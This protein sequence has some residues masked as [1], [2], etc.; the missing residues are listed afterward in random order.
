MLRRIATWNPARG[1]WET[2]AAALCGHWEPYSVTWPGSGMTRSGSAFEPPTSGL[3]TAA[4]ASS[5][6]PHLPTPAARD[7]KGRDL[8]RQGGPSLPQA[9]HDLAE[10]EPETLLPTP[11]AAVFNDGQSPEVYRA[12]KARELAK[13]YN[14]NGGGT[15]LAMAVR[16]LPTILA[17]SGDAGP[18][19]SRTDRPEA[20]GDDLLTTMVKLLPTTTA[21]DAKGSRRAT[22]RRPGQKAHTGTTLTDAAWRLSGVSTAPPSDD[23]SASS[24]EPPPPRPAPDRGEGNGSIPSSRSG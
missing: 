12:R 9:I 11:D 15:P 23:G 4:A 21:T 7:G 14:G 22:A 20:G 10:R 6:S 24:D 3:R 16:L 18:D 5:S 13:G 19:F 1:V 8:P 17:S 2:D